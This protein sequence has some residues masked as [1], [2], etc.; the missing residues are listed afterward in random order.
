MK[1]CALLMLIVLGTSTAV[2][3]GPWANVI[4]PCDAC[5]GQDTIIKV[6]A[7]LPGTFNECKTNVEWCVKGNVILVDIYLTRTDKCHGSLQLC[8]DVN[9]MT[10]CPGRYSA[11]ARVYIKDVGPCA[12]YSNYVISAVGSAIF[13]VANCNPCCPP[14]VW[15]F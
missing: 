2:W 7:C 3:A 9:L 5:S 14:W 10:L 13:D 11:V 8:E 15:P 12:W 1:K 6:G 4:V